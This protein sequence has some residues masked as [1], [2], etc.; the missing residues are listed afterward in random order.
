MDAVMIAPAL[1]VCLP[2]PRRDVANILLKIPPSSR[3]I[4]KAI[5]SPAFPLK[6]IASAEA[7]MTPM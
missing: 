7:V 1:L 2:V 6:F 3:K 4:S 5:L